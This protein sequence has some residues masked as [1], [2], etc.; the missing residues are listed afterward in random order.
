MLKKLEVLEDTYKDLSEKIG[1]PDVI[2]DQKVWQR[3]IK[4]H[5]DL[6]PIVMKYREYKS[7]LDS[8]KESKEILQEESDEELRELAK[9]ELAEMEEK[10]APLEEEIKI[11]LLPKDPNDDK[12]V[13]VEIRGGAGGDE[14]ALFAGD[15]FRMYSRYA[16]RRR[17]KIE[18]LSASD[19]GVGGYKEVSFM[20][21]GK[22]AYSRLKYESGV[23]RVQRIPST[24]SGGRIHTSTSTVAVLPEVE[25]VEVE[26]NPNDLRI[27][28]FRSSGNGG[29]SVNTTDS[30]VR[31]THIPTGEVVSCQ[32]GKSQL[33]NKEQ[34]LKILKARLY[35]KAL[36][37]Q[38]KDIAAERKSQVGT[39][40]R[41]ER[42]RTYNFPQGRIS[43][44]RIN[45]TLYKLDAFLDG[46]IDE[47]IDALITVDQTEKMTAI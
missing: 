19:T 11:L 4:E 28:V 8:I 22:G 18:L 1:D 43:D 41:S 10:V 26:I 34:A 36:A 3:Y 24:E 17:W 13:I 6:E 15:L 40:D 32:D 27:D 47:M 42:I 31:V 14:A 30:A 2:N 9:M 20:I 29:Q 37:E 39:G 33:K 45:L 7:V 16:E 38:H 35:D 44:H 21:K 5:A 46:D 12:N 23:H 25:D